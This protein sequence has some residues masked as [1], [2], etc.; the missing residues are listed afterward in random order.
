MPLREEH[1]TNHPYR[2]SHSGQAKRRKQKARG[3]ARARRPEAE[4]WREDPRWEDPEAEDFP[5][6]APAR[7]NGAKRRERQTAR[8]AKGPAPRRKSEPRQAR[9][10]PQRPGGGEERAGAPLPGPRPRGAAPAVDDAAGAGGVSAGGIVS[11]IANE[12]VRPLTEAELAEQLHLE[13][14]EQLVQLKVL[15]RR[16][17]ADGT[18]VLSRKKRYGLP[19][20]FHLLVGTIS[21]HPKGYGFLQVDGGG[22]EDVYIHASDLG[23][24]THGD[25]VIVRLKRDGSGDSRSG[26]GMRAEGEVIR[27]LQRSTSHV[28]GT[29]EQE[30][31]FGFVTPDD[32]RFGS[33]IFI[34]KADFGGARSGMKVLVEI[35]DWPRNNR[36]AAGRIVQLIGEKGAPGVDVLSILFRHGLPLKFPDAVLEAADAIPETIPA[37]EIARRRDLRGQLLITIDGEDSKDLD[38]AVS[39]ERLPNGNYRLGVHIADVGYYVP[40]DSVLDQEAF[41]RATSV[42]LVDRVVPMLPPKLSNGVCSLNAGE[43]RLAL[44]CVMEI[45]GNGVVVAHEI[46]ESLIR[47]KFRMTYRVV[48]SLL[49]GGDAALEEQYASLLPMLREME[50][51][52]GILERKRLRRGAVNFY[53]PESKVLLDADGHPVDIQWRAHGIA[54]QIIEEFMLCANETVA[55]HYFW[56]GVPFLYRVHEAPKAESIEEVNLFLQALGYSIKGTGGGVHPQAYQNVVRQAAGRPEEALVNTVLLRSMQHARYDTE[57]L[58]HFGLSA[59]YYTHFTSPIRRYPDLAIHRVIKELLHRENRMDEARREALSHKMGR[60]ALQS[61]AREKVAE[62]AERDSV[63]LKK[64]E[65]MQP[66]VGETFPATI[67]GVTNFGIFVQLENSVEGLVHI[68]TLVD[69]FYQFRPERYALC[70]EHTR[71]IYQLGQTLQVRLTRVNVEDRQIDFEVVK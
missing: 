20:Q 34:D 39:V 54:D 27:I 14:V 21:R 33:D 43:D 68:S 15:L 48:S 12:A 46:F 10:L 59:Q 52:E 11:Y 24:A 2:D 62:E 41:A 16:L 45:D 58:G 19:E 18:L 42:Y 30:K 56:M 6:Q 61:S 28:V 49:A 22:Q 26:S 40:E 60:Y 53:M 37:A 13:T 70:G 32:K 55:E 47:V 64:A 66:H 1:P 31:H 29:F 9:A 3:K 71:Q 35:T 67:S 38:D 57:A 17:E 36:G 25:R 65:F 51:L 4:D 50:A 5:A 23:G 63:D 7:Q 44:S 8:P 69:D